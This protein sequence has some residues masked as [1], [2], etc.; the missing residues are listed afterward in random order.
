MQELWEKNF[1]YCALEDYRLTLR[2][3]QIGKALF[4]G[5][6]TVLSEVF[7]TLPDL[8]REPTNF[9]QSEKRL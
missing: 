6:G 7:K 5:V 3:Q 1:S 9:C 2:A 8:N 4:K